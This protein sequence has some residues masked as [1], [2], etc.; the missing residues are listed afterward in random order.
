[1]DDIFAQLVEYA[2]DVRIRKIHFTDPEFNMPDLTFST[3]ILKEI[4]RRGFDYRFAFSS[5]LVAGRMESSF[6]KLLRK[7]NL[8]DFGFT[9]D[10]LSDKTLL[11]NG[12]TYDRATIRDNIDMCLD[13]GIF[14]LINFIVGMHGET[15]EG[16]EEIIDFC[17]S[18]DGA[19]LEFSFVFGLRIYDGTALGRM[20]D[21]NPSGNAPHVYGRKTFEWL[22]PKLFFRTP[23][24]LRK[25]FAFPQAP[26]RPEKRGHVSLMNIFLFNSLNI[27]PLDI[28]TLFPEEAQPFQATVPIGLLNLAGSIKHM[29]A[30]KTRI[31]DLNIEAAALKCG[32]ADLLPSLYE[33]IRT[34]VSEEAG[35][36]RTFLAGFQTLCTSHHLA[37]DL[38]RRMKDDFP[39]SLMLFGGPQSS[40]VADET[41][42]LF[43]PVD[44]ILSGEADFSFPLLVEAV[45]HQRDLES[46]AGLHF[47]QGPRDVRRTGRAVPPEDLDALP[48]PD[49]DSYP[50]PV[51]PLLVEAGRGCPNNCAFCFTGKFFSRRC[52]YKSAQRLEKEL[53]LLKDRFGEP[54]TVSFQHDNLFGSA[55]RAHRLCN[56][57]AALAK[58]LHFDWNCFI[59]LDALQNPRIGGLL[60]NAGCKKVFIGIESGSEDVQKAIHKY[61]NVSSAYEVIPRLAGQGLELDLGFVLEFPGERPDDVEK[62]LRL[63]AFSRLHEANFQINPLM[64]YSGTAMFEQ[65]KNKLVYD[66]QRD[67]TDYNK[68]FFSSPGIHEMLQKSPAMFSVFYSFPLDHEELKGIATLAHFVM[69][70]FVHT[71]MA[72]ALWSGKG[73]RI[74]DICL[75]LK[76]YWSDDRVGFVN[77][78]E[79]WAL[80]RFA[81][82][83]VITE[84][85]RYEK[86][87]FDC[88]LTDKYAWNPR[89]YP[90]Q[91]P[92]GQGGFRNLRARRGDRVVVNRYRMSPPLAAKD[93]KS[94]LPGRRH[95]DPRPGRERPRLFHQR[96]RAE[97]REVFRSRG[98]QVSRHFLANIRGPHRNGLFRGRGGRSSRR[99]YPPRGDLEMA[100]SLFREEPS[101]FHPP[102]ALT[103]PPAT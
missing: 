26:G 34:I 38:A 94:A 22:K 51:S 46:V 90:P 83:P 28:I 63:V 13:N 66:P 7:A 42:E 53:A 56:A 49:Y 57:L 73:M 15:D 35:G 89:L 20:V 99:G 8:R 98:L 101:L 87:C 18:Y 1:M 86:D 103:A 55:E 3:A 100:L 85:F 65:H 16:L 52:R 17:K 11:M 76:P 58:R 32:M 12:K 62:S 14:L 24:A 29:E 102:D 43:P 39:E 25:L 30:C 93:F 67:T 92:S 60:R 2:K 91:S 72:I 45:L 96:R 79:R 77:A 78:F 84:L 69:R 19:R 95:A 75:E 59:R 54:G 41:M 50:Y 6:V 23:F 70:S 71:C 10:C 47:R 64:I 68:C 9:L 97:G 74:V 31:I 80:G 40:A 82:C 88:A 4:V 44:F 27:F 81:D 36:E 5:Q 21:A 61:R 37:L 48:F 33:R